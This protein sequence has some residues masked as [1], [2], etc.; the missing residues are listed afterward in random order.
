[1]S[2]NSSEAP[3]FKKV[4]VHIPPWKAP[5]FPSSWSHVSITWLWKPRNVLAAWWSDRGPGS[6]CWRSLDMPGLFSCHLHVRKRG[7]SQMTK[8]E[9][10]GSSLPPRSY[11]FLYHLCSFWK[12]WVLS[13][14]TGLLS[15][16]Y[17]IPSQE[18]ASIA[19]PHNS[20]RPKDYSCNL[21]KAN[22]RTEITH[23]LFKIKMANNNT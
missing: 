19:L 22:R 14:V 6:G 7:W 12:L 3:L 21:I 5:A 13:D 8:L 10:G 23:Q 9:W 15:S 2:K 4:W 18:K 17:V 11:A 20:S 1:M 16:A